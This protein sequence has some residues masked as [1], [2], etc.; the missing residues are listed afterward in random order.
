MS[1]VGKNPVSVPKD[2]K[3]NI[4]AGKVN[5]EGAKGKLVL[6]VPNGINVEFKDE[7]LMVTRVSNAKQNRA[8]HGTIRAHLANM[9]I[10]VTEGH[11]KELELQGIGFRAQLQGSK[12]SMNLGFSHPV[13]Y[14]IPDY[15][16]ATVTKLLRQFSSYGLHD[17]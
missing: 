13:E 8:N 12:L 6:R 14:E 10:G 1:R 17:H 16:K 9:I 11:K 15:V 4:D 2:V 3:V 5:V 7:Q